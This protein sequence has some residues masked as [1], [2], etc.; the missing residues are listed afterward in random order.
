[1]YN[2]LWYRFQDIAH[3]VIEPWNSLGNGAVNC[4]TVT[5][6][7]THLYVILVAMEPRGQLTPQ[8]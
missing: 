2:K 4:N 3:Q 7:K 8:R 5:I 1:M 6:F